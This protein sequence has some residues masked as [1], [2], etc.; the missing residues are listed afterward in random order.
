MV[1]QKISKILIILI[2]KKSKKNYQTTNIFNLVQTFSNKNQNHKVSNKTLIK[3]MKTVIISIN[4]HN[5][6]LKLRIK[7]MKI[8]KLQ[9]INTTHNNNNRHN[10]IQKKKQIKKFQSLI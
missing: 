10:N 2:Q 4:N 8:E 6:K 5:I 3:S 7:S 9:N 1:I